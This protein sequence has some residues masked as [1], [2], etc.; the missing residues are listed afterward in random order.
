LTTV[1]CYAVAYARFDQTV[2]RP[3][4]TAFAASWRSDTGAR[5]RRHPSYQAIR[6]FISL[7][8]SRSGLHQLVFCALF[9][10]GLALALDRLLAKSSNGGGWSPTAIISAPFTLMAGATIGLRLA[11][12][13]PTSL[14]AAW[15]FRLAEHQETRRHQLDAVRWTLF[16]WGAGIPAALAAPFYLT[17][18]GIPAGAAG[19]SIVLLLGSILTE[20]FTIGWRRVPFTCSFLFAKHPPAYNVLLALLIFGWFVFFGWVF[21]SIAQRGIRPWLLVVAVLG[22]TS[23]GLSRYR[24]LTWGQFP[25]EFE[26]YMPDDVHPLKLGP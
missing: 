8:V 9:A 17:T 14:R 15:I 21:V 22:A 24:H 13:L 19:L 4:H 26:D 20:M 10:T 1:V 6:R 11:F 23:A 5:A 7:T 16:Q 25:L 3:V 12:L 2:L 18:L